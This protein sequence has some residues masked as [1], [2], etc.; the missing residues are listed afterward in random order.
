MNRNLLGTLKGSYDMRPRQCGGEIFKAGI[1]GRNP[2]LASSGTEPGRY[3]PSV[4][5]STTSL[6]RKA[7][8]FFS[9]SRSQ[10]G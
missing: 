9:P 5:K 4:S 3:S 7:G 2:V 10:S 8:F 6:G 1:T